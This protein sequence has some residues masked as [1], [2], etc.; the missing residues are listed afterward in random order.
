MIKNLKKTIVSVCAFCLCLIF[1][2]GISARAAA[3]VKYAEIPVLSDG[4][5]ITV[6]LKANNT[7]YVPIRE[8]CLAIEPEALVLWEKDTGTAT[9]RTDGL[10]IELC[11]KDSYMTAND[12]FLYFE[13]GII[14]IN[15]TA[16]VPLGEICLAFGIKPLQDAELGAVVISTENR[17]YITS[18]EDYYDSRDIFW[19]SRLINSEA[20]NQP[21]EGKIGV[22]NVVLNRVEDPACPDTIFDVIFDCK[23]GVQFSVIATGAIYGAPNEES[24]IAAKIC[25][26]GYNTVGGSIYFFNPRISA[27]NWITTYRTFVTGIGDHYFYF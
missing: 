19:L 1:S 23:Y 2:G 26:E 20:G 12:R 4:I 15:G 5:F 8:F 10:I 16:Y 25:L 17:E 24:E 13:D 6:G 14:N 3:Q 21:I 9:V 27:S 18:A 22:G 11:L 7:I